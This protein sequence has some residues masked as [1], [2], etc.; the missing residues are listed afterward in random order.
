MTLFLRYPISNILFNRSVLVNIFTSTSG[1]TGLVVIVPSAPV[2]INLNQKEEYDE[3]VC[4]DC[5]NVGLFFFLFRYCLADEDLKANEKSVHDEFVKLVPKDKII[6]IETFKP[7][8]DEI[9]AGT[10]KAY[11]IDCRTHPEF[12]AFHI[13]GADHIHAGHM[14]TIPK[15]I[16]DPNTEIYLFAGHNTA[17]LCCRLFI[18]IRL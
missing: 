2:G 17:A 1:E 13:E 8:H 15:K 14:Y 18:Q 10:R 16:P 4:M 5:H 12:Y 11:M 9:L 3:K 7:I 6:D